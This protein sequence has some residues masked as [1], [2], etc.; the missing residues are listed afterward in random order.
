MGKPQLV[1]GARDPAEAA[2]VDEL[3]EGYPGSSR[4][5]Q[6]AQGARIR[7]SIETW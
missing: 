1:A 4:S 6:N 5:S 2:V 3:H 7:V